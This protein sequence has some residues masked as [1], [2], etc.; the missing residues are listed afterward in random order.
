MFG[1]NHHHE[2]T[3][4]KYQGAESKAHGGKHLHT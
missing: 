2:G 1:I 3:L 4:V